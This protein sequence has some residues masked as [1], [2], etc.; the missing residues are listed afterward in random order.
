MFD[1]DSPEA[2]SDTP[3]PRNTKKDDEVQDVYSTSTKTNS[4]SLA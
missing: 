2:M 1:M 3:G 4:I